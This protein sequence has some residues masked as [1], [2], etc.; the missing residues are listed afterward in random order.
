VCFGPDVVAAQNDPFDR[1]ARHWIGDGGLDLRR[2]VGAAAAQ[3]A[4]CSLNQRDIG[5]GA[6]QC[7]S[8]SPEEAFATR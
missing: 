8:S 6:L 3:T 7:R 4:D 2:F 1:L 5:V